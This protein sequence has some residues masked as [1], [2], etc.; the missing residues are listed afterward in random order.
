MADLFENKYMECEGV[1][2]DFLYTLDQQTLGT[3]FA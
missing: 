3:T 2:V 1:Y